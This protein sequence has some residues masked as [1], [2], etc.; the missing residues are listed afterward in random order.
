MTLSIS[1]E[2]FHLKGLNVLHIFLFLMSRLSHPYVTTRPIHINAFVV[3]QIL[4]LFHETILSL[5]N[6]FIIDALLDTADCTQR[7]F[8]L[9]FRYACTKFH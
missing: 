9:L 7:H 8:E 6:H 2:S 1:A 3:M 5:I 4:W